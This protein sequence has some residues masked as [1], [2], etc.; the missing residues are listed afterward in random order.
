MGGSDPTYKVVWM[1]VEL[2]LIPTFRFSVVL[3]GSLD[4][5]RSNARLQIFGGQS[6]AFIILTLAFPVSDVLKIEA[7]IILIVVF[8]I[9]LAKTFT[10]YSFL[11]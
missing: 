7:R 8:E 9:A 1:V 6:P 10:S 2:E 11:A 5:Y 4:L 3:D